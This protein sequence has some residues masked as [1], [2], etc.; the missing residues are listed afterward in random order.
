MK[1]TYRIISR[2][3]SRR[4][5]RE[6]PHLDLPPN[7]CFQTTVHSVISHNCR[8]SWTQRFLSGSQRNKIFV[9]RNQNMEAMVS[10]NQACGL[11]LNKLRS[12]LCF[13]EFDLV[14]K[15][16]FKETPHCLMLGPPSSKQRETGLQLRKVC[17]G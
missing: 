1:L 12:Q 2:K 17:V 10:S 8:V 14:T 13:G 9:E 3:C 5:N 11:D 7:T 6:Y 4:D 15:F 16:N